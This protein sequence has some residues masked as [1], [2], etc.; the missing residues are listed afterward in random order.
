MR[1]S[2]DVQLR[3]MRAQEPTDNWV[4]R[5]KQF[6]SSLYFFFIFLNFLSILMLYKSSRWVMGEGLNYRG[7]INFLKFFAVDEWCY[8]N[9]Y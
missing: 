8:F 4:S 5:L 1:A 2:V 7:L 6:I 9:Y 3:D